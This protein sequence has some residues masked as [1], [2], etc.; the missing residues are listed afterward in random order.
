MQLTFIDPSELADLL[1]NADILDYVDV[2]GQRTYIL[3]HRGADILAFVDPFSGAASLVYSHKF[4]K[5]AGG[6][7]HQWARRAWRL[8]S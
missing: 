8:L 7:V 3:T 2:G 6:S 4:D 1:A 5:R